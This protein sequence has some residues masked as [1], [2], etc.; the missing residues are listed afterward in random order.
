MVNVKAPVCK[1]MFLAGC[2]PVQGMVGSGKGGGFCCGD[3]GECA[4][5][6]LMLGPNTVIEKCGASWR[7]VEAVFLAF[8]TV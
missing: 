2:P 4:G 5:L 1:L 7:F 8:L 3:E 6:S